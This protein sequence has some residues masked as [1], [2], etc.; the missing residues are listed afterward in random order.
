MEA[1]NAI[2][3]LWFLLNLG[4]HLTWASSSQVSFINVYVSI[5]NDSFLWQLNSIEP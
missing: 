1:H 2:K 3:A 5:V 4:F